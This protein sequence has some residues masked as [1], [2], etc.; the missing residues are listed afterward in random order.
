VNDQQY[1]VTV[2]FP[3]PIHGY[4]DGGEKGSGTFEPHILG[5]CHDRSG[6]HPGPGNTI[7]W[8]CFRLNFW[9]TAKSGRSWREAASIAKRMLERMCGIAGTTIVVVEL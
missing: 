9:F 5:D 2:T 1:A 6:G 3:E 7:R 4:W 8:G